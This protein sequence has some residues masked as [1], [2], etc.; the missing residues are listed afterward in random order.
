MNR[1][2]FK[3]YNY[4]SAN[5]T[6][7]FFIS[8]FS[9]M[10]AFAMTM[11]GA[12]NLTESQMK[13]FL[14]LD[15]E[16]QDML[17]MF[18]NYFDVLNMVNNKDTT[19]TVANRIFVR[20]GLKLYQ[21]FLNNVNTYFKSGVEFVDFNNG[22]ESARIVNGWVSGRTNNKIN[23]LIDPSLFTPMTSMFLINAIYFKGKL[24]N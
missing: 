12:R 20:L 21:D 23:N 10:T 6:D 7:N 14:C 11:V 9:I 19:L 17:Q 24:D 4:L 16:Q 1:F 13:T 5:K 18:S 8:P 22:N 15:V 3:I 2:A